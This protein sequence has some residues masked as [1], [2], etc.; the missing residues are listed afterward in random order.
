VLRWRRTLRKN[1]WPRLQY[2][3]TKNNTNED[4]WTWARE[5]FICGKAQSEIMTI[6]PACILYMPAMVLCQLSLLLGMSNRLTSLIKLPGHLH[7][8]W[9]HY[10]DNG[11]IECFVLQLGL[12]IFKETWPMETKPLKNL[13]WSLVWAEPVQIDPLAAAPQN[14]QD[15]PDSFKRTM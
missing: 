4:W 13:L 11:N 9:A 15:H 10:R 3:Q 6:E 1:G 8:L 5:P 14:E 12:S 2:W 7:C